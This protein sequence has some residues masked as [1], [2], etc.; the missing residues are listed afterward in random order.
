MEVFDFILL[1]VIDGLTF[2]LQ[3]E[4]SR[5]MPLADI[6]SRLVKCQKRLENVGLKVNLAK[7]E[8]M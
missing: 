1:L 8:Q 2:D 4:A 5:C 6:Q 3:D 7:M